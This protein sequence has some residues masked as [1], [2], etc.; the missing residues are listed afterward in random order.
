[1]PKKRVIVLMGG[2]TPE[3]AV[4]LVSGREVVR[5]LSK[6]KHQVLPVIISP[7]GE[8]WRLKPINQILRLS[9]AGVGKF[10]SAKKVIKVQGTSVSR[11]L[12]PTIN[13]NLQPDVVFLAMHG[14]FGED[15]TIQGMLEL[16]G[17][18]YTGS[19]VLAS[20]LGMD[21]IMFRKVMEREKIPTPKY[22]IFRLK[23]PQKKIFSKFTLPLIVKPSNQG[24]SVG[25]SLVFSR[26]KLRQALELAFSFSRE[27]LIE[28]YLKGT[29]VSCG[30]LG[31]D[32]PKSLP[33]VEIVPRTD[34]FDYDAKYHSAMCEEIVPARISKKQTKLVQ[35]LAVRVFKVIGCRGF[36]RVDMIIRRGRPYVLE[37]NTIPGLTPNSLFPKEAAAAG[38]SY[39]RLLDRIIELALEK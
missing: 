31:N 23:D 38:I 18:P 37:I 10:L 5:H 14:P 28:E 13:K 15:G 21:K 27:I 30:V 39:S 4:S 36:G 19:G 2:K 8:Q 32:R 25:V 26:K 1:M 11:Q 35:E 34:F 7:D 29:E 9:P 22:M 24:S 20:A 6:R 33:V 12:V 17:V 3:H 16:S